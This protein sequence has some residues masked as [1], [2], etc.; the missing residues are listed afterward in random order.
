MAVSTGISLYAA[1]A[2]LGQA[3]YIGYFHRFECHLYAMRY[4]QLFTLSCVGGIVALINLHGQSFSEAA[5]LTASIAGSFLA[6][7]YGSLT[8][9]RLFLNPLNK[10]PGPYWA[11]LGNIYMSLHFRNSDAYYKLQALHDQHGRI[12]RIGSN[13]LSITHPSIM[14]A[15][16]GRHSTCSKGWW[17]DGDAPWSSMHT[18]RSRALHDARRKVWAPAFAEKALRDYERKVDGFSDL[19][20]AKIAE[21][22]GRA[23]DVRNWFNLFSFDVMAMLAFGKDYGMLEKGEKHWALELLDEGMQPLAFFLPTW[24]FRFLTAIPGLAAGYHNFIQ[25]CVDE[26]NWRID[27]AEEQDG[28]GGSDIMSWILR[29]YKEIH[30]PG[31]DPMLQADARLIIVAGSDT[32]AAT[33]TYLFYHL[34]RHPEEVK[35]LREE[36]R[37]LT[38]GEWSD[39]DINQAEHLNGCIYEALRMHPP[40]PSGLQRLTPPGGLDV[41]G[42]HVPGNTIF[43][44][45]QYVMGRGELTYLSPTTD[46]PR[47]TNASLADPAIYP[48]PDAFVPERWSSRPEMVKHKDAFAPFSAGPMGCI[49]KNLAMS[50]LRTTT[51][52]LVLRFDFGLAEGEDGERLLRRTRDHF[53]VDPGSLDLV[54]RAVS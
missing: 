9:Y 1:A 24:F 5:S 2:V 13:D 48:S 32:T 39:K 6:G 25:F 29:A 42:R 11:R 34:A 14:D 31:K 54:F 44:M 16:Y 27:H 20:V 53:T 30:Q 4:L 10:F 26:L 47:S 35:K 15:V 12:V 3:L 17:Y 19:L 41:D 38:T 45:P 43:Y 37:P 49:G 50:E 40:V 23:V 28:K 46:P 51:A 36:L 7:I 21:R 18:T 22:Q 33:F 8:I 52:K